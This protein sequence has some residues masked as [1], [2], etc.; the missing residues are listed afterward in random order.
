MLIYQKFN[1]IIKSICLVSSIFLFSTLQATANPILDGA[2]IGEWTMDYE[3]A[4]KLAK[5]KNT[6]ILIKFTTKQCSNCKVLEKNILQKKEFIEFAKSN[7]V[8]IWLDYSKKYKITPEK[9]ITR[10][11]ILAE[12][13]NIRGYPELI[14]LESDG[15]TLIGKLGNRGDAKGFIKKLKALEAITPKGMEKYIQAN[16]DKASAFKKAISKLKESEDNFS[17]WL[18]TK[19][20]KSKENDVIHQ[21]MMSNINVLSKSLM[22]V[23]LEN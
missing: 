15:K 5:K 23:V 19:P 13:Y 12:I 8:L 14:Y 3:A 7:L 1:N 16:P 2:K 17:D 6:N 10:N 22:N 21:Q 20:K 9:Y 4:L 18:L 11:E